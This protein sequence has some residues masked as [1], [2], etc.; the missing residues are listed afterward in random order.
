MNVSQLLDLHAAGFEIGAHSMTHAKLTMLPQDEA[1]DEISRSKHELEC[2]MNTTV[3]S[4]SYPYELVDDMTKTMVKQAGYTIACGVS[5]GPATF[6]KD[7]Y[8]VRRLAIHNT[9]STLGLGLRLLTPFHYYEWI[10]WK[11]RHALLNRKTRPH[12]APWGVEEQELPYVHLLETKR[13]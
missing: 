7:A 10:R 5:T 9:T 6:G 1:W 3:R 2:L 4:F 12:T 13:R 8:E 11:V